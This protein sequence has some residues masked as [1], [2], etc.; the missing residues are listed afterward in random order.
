MNLR[1]RVP[2]VVGV[3]LALAI[4]ATASVAG[5]P[6]LPGALDL[7]LLI[8]GA[9]DARPW[10]HPLLLVPPLHAPPARGG[11][12]LLPNWEVGRNAAMLLPNYGPDNAVTFELLD[13]AGLSGRD[14]PPAAPHA[15]TI[16]PARP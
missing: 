10:N 7:P 4:V 6:L 1:T 11:A 5:N 16:D 13:F 3:A 8:D 15:A 9:V 2:F 12:Q 14:S